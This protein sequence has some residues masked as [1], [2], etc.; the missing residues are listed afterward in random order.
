MRFEAGILKSSQPSEQ[1]RAEVAG[2]I[3]RVAMH[4][5][6]AD[7]DGHDDQT[8]HERIEGRCYWLVAG[9]HNGEDQAHQERGTNH[10]VKEPIAPISDSRSRK[11]GENAT[12]LLKSGSN[13]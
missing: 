8:N 11:G 5:T 10:L 12:V 2:R 1:T 9:I 4:P 6:P 3:D 7:P 13:S